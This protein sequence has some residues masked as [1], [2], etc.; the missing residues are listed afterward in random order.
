[1]TTHSLIL[2]IDDELATRRLLRVA[3]AS[4]GYRLAEA[5][6][7]REGL[8][9]AATLR[10][11]LII[12]DLE[13]PDIDGLQVIKQLREW[14]STPIF[15]LSAR[16]QEGDK[17]AALD[18]GADDYLTKPCS[19]GELLARMRAALRH[20][21]HTNQKMNEPTVTV[22]ELRVN[23]MM[24]QVV[25]GDDVIHLTPIEYRLLTALAQHTGKVLT[26]TQLLKQV[27]GPAYTDAAHYVRVH[28]AQLRRKLEID[29]ACP[30]YL[31]TEPRVGYR[32]AAE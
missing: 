3:L 19:V 9:Q 23:L 26:H 20:V 14:I 29:P 15:V 22:G 6:A 27:W 28:M 4:Q 1:M 30:R 21:A 31:L 10:P 2:I 8:A 11:D 32:L 7:G 25:L 16:C 24:R 5:V 13:L 12:L 17:V 18:G